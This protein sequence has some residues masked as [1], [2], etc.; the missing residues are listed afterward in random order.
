MLMN[1]FT[2]NSNKNIQIPWAF[3][4]SLF[5]IF[6]TE[7]F[8]NLKFEEKLLSH[9]VDWTLYSLK[10]TKYNA[11]YLLLGDS[12]GLQLA[13]AY[14]QDPKFAVLATNQAIE[15]TGQYFI[16]KRYLARNPP[17]KAVIF[18]AR[19]FL[20]NNLD[21]V[22]TENFVLRTFTGLDEI[23]E[24]FTTKH[25]LTM[26]A[27]MLAYK[28]VVTYKYKLKLQEKIIG[29][30]NADIYSG[31]D[32]TSYRAKY[33]GYSLV[34]LF[35][36]VKNYNK[37]N[38]SLFHLKKILALLN[39]KKIDF[40]YIPVP[41]SVKD[42][43]VEKKYNDLFSNKIKK[44]L[45]HYPRAFFLKRYEKYP[46]SMFVD[47]VHFNEKGMVLAKKFMQNELTFIK[48]QTSR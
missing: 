9:E 20:D 17:P 28:L 44:I 23:V 42:S 7:Y 26:L 14:Y 10:K 6:C 46:K 40:Y 39:I 29:Y 4:L 43:S 32:K 11:D 5:L 19:P 38:S 36:R 35:D 21:Q 48:K 16:L 27:K 24:I 1:L 33:K 47:G 41:I 18:I 45:E 3:L 8:V 31:L 13:K 15:P 30:T 22:Y 34:N 12:V 2:F 37:E 25:D